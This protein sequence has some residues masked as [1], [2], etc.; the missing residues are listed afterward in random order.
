MTLTELKNIISESIQTVLLDE[1]WYNQSATPYFSNTDVHN[2]IGRNPLTVDNGNHSA[3]DT[4]TQPSTIDFNGAKLDA[5]MITLSDNGYMIYKI[6]NFGDD[7]KKSTL[8]FF[9]RSAEGEKAFRC[10]IDT[11]YGAGSRNGRRPIFRTISATSANVRKNSISNCFWEF[12]FD[13]GNEWFIV[14]PNPVQ[15]MN[16]SKLLRK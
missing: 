7:K 14:K 2:N 15:N 11:I 9:G 4:V 16:K 5:E 13:G 8:D 3:H 6:K 10:A 1:G 12:S